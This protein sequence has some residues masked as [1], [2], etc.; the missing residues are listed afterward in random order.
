MAAANHL[1]LVVV[2]VVVLLVVATT[3][4]AAAAGS[5]A[6]S[7]N[8]TST[9]TAYEMLE[10][11]DFPRGILPEGVE[12]YVLRPDGSFEVYFPRDC[13]FLLART[14]LVQYGSRIAG[15]AS[16]GSLKSL[17]GIYVKV[18]FIWLPVGEVDRSGDLLS[19][20]IGPVATSFPLADFANSPH[21]R[22]YNLAA[23]L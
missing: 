21:C 17:Q 9:P 10:R 22:G 1:V 18:L 19:F 23:A 15:A 7:G 6:A 11:Y 3:P 5:A 16:S 13:E 12:G 4:G 14:W 2:V 8:G 20:Y